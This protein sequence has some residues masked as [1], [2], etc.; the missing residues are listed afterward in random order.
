MTAIRPRPTPEQERRARARYEARSARET[1]TLL[2]Q[3]RFPLVLALF[4]VAL[5]VVPWALTLRIATQPSFIIAVYRY[6]TRY[7]VQ[8]GWVI[9][10]K[11]LNSLA[12]VLSLPILSALLARA[13]VVF[14]QRRRP[15]QTLSVLQLFAL[16]DRDWYNPLGVLSPAGSSALLRLGFLL[17]LVSLLLPLVR[18]GLVTYGNVLVSSH[19]PARYN[20]A[21][22]Y[23][24]LTPGPAALKQGTALQ[25]SVTSATRENLRI[26]TGGIDA[27]LW[28]VCNDPRPGSTCGFKYGPYDMEQSRLSNFW[29]SLS[30]DF[31]HRGYETNGSALMLASTLR[32]GSTIGTYGEND[33]GAYTLGLQSGA[34]CEA[35]PVQT[36]QEQCIRS[37]DSGAL[38]IA[39]R[40]WNTSVE[41]PQRIRLDIC[42]PPLE[43]DPWEAADASPWKPINFTEHLYVGVLDFDSDLGCGT[44]HYAADGCLGDSSNLYFHCQADSLMSYFE[45]GKASTNGVP[46]R[47]LEEMPADFEIGEMSDN[48]S[49]DN[50]GTQYFGP[51]KTAT[52]AMFGNDSWV[53]MLNQLMVDVEVSNVTLS[54]AMTILCSMQPLGHVDTFNNNNVCKYTNYPST[55][56]LYSDSETFAGFIRGMLE[57]FENRQLARDTLNTATFYANTALLSAIT[58]T[59]YSYV[60]KEYKYGT[61]ETDEQM[62]VPLLSVAAIATVSTLLALQVLGIFILLVYIYSSRVW[63]RTLD[64]L[65]VARIGAQLSALDVFLVPRET[66]TLG[67]ARITRRAVKQLEQI[68]GLVGSTALTGQHDIEMAAM[69][70]PYSPRGEEPSTREEQRIPQP[71]GPHAAGETAASDYPVPSYSPPPDEPTTR[72]P[73]DETRAVGRVE[74]TNDMTISQSY[75][76]SAESRGP[77]LPPVTS[78]E[79]LA[80]GGRGLVPRRRWYGAEKP[81]P[82]RPAE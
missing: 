35:V 57:P 19:W 39:A 6:G 51:L 76:A 80:V 46:G 50:P 38:P 25:T 24:G 16:A 56:S 73:G 68:E 17:L 4:Y 5:L 78:I 36:V 37:T 77:A 55:S 14:S 47:L 21:H 31:S 44:S 53:H 42:Y 66:G 71:G 22:E 32:A 67:P 26:T 63:T 2:S 61:V 58:D 48:L 34:Q 79:A 64:A 28:P 8:Y 41:I 65:A 60:N 54:A 82:P 1:Q 70:P 72:T 62:F 45:M 59:G 75:V 12:A 33:N 23:I 29:E 15:G 11:V 10:I 27:N 3:S 81:L 18:S 20:M 69:P 74:T 13:A 7:Y 49:D 40:G 9:A 52:M 30:D 43:R